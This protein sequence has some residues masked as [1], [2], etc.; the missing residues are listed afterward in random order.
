MTIAAEP[1]TLIEAALDGDPALPTLAVAGSSPET[2]AVHITPGVPASEI[3]GTTYYRTPPFRP[4]TLTELVV[5]IQ[6]LRWRRSAPLIPLAMPPTEAD[7]QALHQK[8]RR[9]TVRF[10]CLPGWT[11]V[12][13]TVFTWLDE[14]AP[15][16]SWQTDQ[17]KE[18]YATLRLYRSG[19]LPEP[20]DAIIAAAE[21]LSG[22]V[23]EDCGAP[24]RYRTGMAGGA[25]AVRTTSAG[26]RHECLSEETMAAG[27]R[28][29]ARIRAESCSGRPNMVKVRVRPAGLSTPYPAGWCAWSAF[30]SHPKRPDGC[31]TTTALVAADEDV[32]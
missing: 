21:H 5:R 26:A 16:H 32:D 18:K 14:I 22:H 20:G 25:R 6:R 30:G 10:E 12:L 27:L 11:G 15:D 1:R 13:D 9:A 4:E 28:E 24:D 8:H 19:D 2:L 31:I 23:C 7:L 3:G 17:V 29:A